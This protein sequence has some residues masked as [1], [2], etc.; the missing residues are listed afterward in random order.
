[1]Q[2]GAGQRAAVTDQLVPTRRWPAGGVGE[3]RHGAS[4]TV[5]DG[6][7]YSGRRRR[8]PVPL[9]GSGGRMT[10]ARLPPGATDWPPKRGGDNRTPTFAPLPHGWAP[11][12]AAPQIPRVTG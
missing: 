3:L 9:P 1:M 6:V 5:G 7:A 12:E 11:V 2:R 8:H 4:L 10:A